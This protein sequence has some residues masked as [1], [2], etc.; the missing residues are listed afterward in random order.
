LGEAKLIRS[1]VPEKYILLRFF[2]GFVICAVRHSN[3]DTSEEGLVAK[4]GKMAGRLIAVAPS[5]LHELLGVSG[6]YV[7]LKQ[8]YASVSSESYSIRIELSMESTKEWPK[9]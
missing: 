4:S 8:V 6:T 1:G 3:P 9:Q 7:A 5:F 2:G